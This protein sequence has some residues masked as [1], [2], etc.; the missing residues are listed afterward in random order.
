MPPAPQPARTPRPP[1]GYDSKKGEIS[2]VM[3]HYS[4]RYLHFIYRHFA[5]DITLAIVLGEI[6]H[7]NVTRH[8]AASTSTREVRRLTKPAP[9]VWSNLEGCNAFSLSQATGIPR[10]TVRRKIA[11]LVRKG[12]IAK[13]PKGDVTITPEL[14][15]HFLPERNVELLLGFLDTTEI[16]QELLAEGAREETK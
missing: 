2:L 15:R 9:A 10:E 16:L 8:F 6:A 1:P 13:S 14:S 11:W 12:W 4:L 7:H 5:G 3:S